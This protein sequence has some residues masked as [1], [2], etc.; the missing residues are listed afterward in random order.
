MRRLLATV[1]VCLLLAIALSSCSSSSSPMVIVPDT[2]PGDQIQGEYMIGKWCT[3]REETA[4]ANQEAGFSAMLNI[5]PVFWRFGT[6]GQWD[7][8]DT[9]YVFDSFGQW[10]ID[11]LNNLLLGKKGGAPKRYHAQFKNGGTNL[12]LTDEKG[13]YWVLSHCS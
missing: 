3:N 10:Q 2:G 4:N 6:E 5:S 11:G 9:G 13:H 8:S 12:F 7:I 1:S